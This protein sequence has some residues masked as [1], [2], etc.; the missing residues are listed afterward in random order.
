MFARATSFH[1]S[2]SAFSVSICRIV[3]ISR[4]PT[5]SEKFFLR[6]R[7]LNSHYPTV[8][9]G[10]KLKKNLAH[11]GIVGQQLISTS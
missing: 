9:K 6:V 1:L 3:L 11:S 7:G 10:N 2:A 4:H 5:T 8:G